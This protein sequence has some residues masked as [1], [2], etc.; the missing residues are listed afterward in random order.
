M[1]VDSSPTLRLYVDGV[2]K[3]ATGIGA[4]GVDNP[5][6]PVRIGRSTIDP[7]YVFGGDIDEVRISSVA[8]SATEIRGY[9]RSR[10]PH[11]KTMWD[12]DVSDAGAAQTACPQS[13]RCADTGYGA[14]GTATPLAGGRYYARQKLRIAG[15]TWSQWSGYD[16]LETRLGKPADLYVGNTTAATGTANVTGITNAAPRLSWRSNANVSVDRQQTQVVTS[17]IDDVLGLWHADGSGTDAS[18]NG[19][20]MT[21]DAAPA[22]PAYG[23]AQS[24]F[25]QSLDFDGDDAGLVPHDPGLNVSTYTVD[26]W[27]NATT[28][29]FD[30]W[31]RFISKLDATRIQMHVRSNPSKGVAMLASTGN[32]AS[33]VVAET[34]TNYFDG[35]WHYVAAVLDQ[36]NTMRLYVDGVQQATASLGG[37]VD[38]TATPLAIGRDGLGAWSQFQGRLDEVRISSVARSASEI[39]GYYATRQPQFQV[40]WDSGEQP[41]ASCA[42]LA[43]CADVTY[44]GSPLIR[45]GARYYARA[46]VRPN[47]QAWTNW[48]DWDWFETTPQTTVTVAPTASLGTALPGADTAVGHDVQVNTTNASGYT[49]TATGPSDTYGMTDG[50]APHVPRWSGAPGSPTAWA[51]GTSGGFGLTVVS[52]TGGKDTARW[53][54]ATSETDYANGRYVGLM[55]STSALLHATT[56][57]NAATDTV[58]VGFRGNV[59]ASVPPGP[60]S[61]TVTFTAV[62]NP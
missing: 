19:R 41:V 29:G 20:T 31:P 38:F 27:F 23:A 56:G 43:R 22:D 11:M 49:L 24:G 6:G 52:A 33:T 3:D 51:A 25:G 61:A 30:N 1:V 18:G 35:Q 13:T 45:P 36:T 12:S 8:R 28:L 32:G 14:T 55:S 46:R 44:A 57:F 60:Y 39:A 17:P 9:Y 26:F 53:G 48:A 2:Q 58:R 10:L 7:T 62:A 34:N 21:L 50:T 40:L 5:A 37:P 59:D 4:G 54:T 16:W 15:G 42:D 47:G